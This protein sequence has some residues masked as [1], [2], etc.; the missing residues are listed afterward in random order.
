[1][2]YFVALLLIFALYLGSVSAHVYV[3]SWKT[4]SY[5]DFQPGQKEW[6]LQDT[7]YRRASDT[8]GWVGSKFL[9]R[10]KAIV[11]GASH[12]P[13]GYVAPP[14]G[15]FFSDAYESAG[16]TLKVRA[17]GKVILNL[18]GD[19]GRGYPHHHGHIQAYL[20]RCGSSP[21]ACQR[22][23]ASTASYFK[24]QE[25]KDGV[26]QLRKQ[27]SSQQGG[28]IWEVPIPK[29]VAAGSYIFRFEIITWGESV[30]SEGFQ[31]QYYPSC[32]QL[33]VQS[34]RKVP[35]SHIPSIKLPGG[36]HDGNLPS[37]SNLPGPIVYSEYRRRRSL[38]SPSKSK[39]AKPPTL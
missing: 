31:D 5:S 36:Y 14:G 24:I 6:K 33:Y 18:E 12:T 9:T 27:Y 28:D 7:A 29:D 38:R 1:M 19:T 39:T 23:D 2:T 3:K 32:G 4:T 30:Q 34:E 21:S 8:I 11:C 35:A 25:K 10:N 16:K 26:I 13:K 22:F 37:S 15:R 20:G 17:G